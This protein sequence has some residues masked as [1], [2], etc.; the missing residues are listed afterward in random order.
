M[1][2]LCLFARA[3]DGIT[4]GRLRPAVA[5]LLGVPAGECT[6]RQVDYDLRR[7]ARKQL[8]RRVPGKLCYMLTPFG[9]RAV[10]FLTKIHARVLRPRIT[11]PRLPRAQRR[12]AAAAR[13]LRGPRCGNRFIS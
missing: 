3:S 9:R 5:Q 11:S 8:I 1:G 4:N 12:T 13:G 7:L 6:A 10:L 2:A